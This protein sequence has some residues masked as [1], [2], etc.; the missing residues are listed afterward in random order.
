METTNK[1][2]VPDKMYTARVV[3]EISRLRHERWAI[4]A[5]LS[6]NA[7]GEIETIGENGKARMRQ[8]LLTIHSRLY[9]LTGNKIYDVR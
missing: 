4:L 8:R 5:A 2:V 7:D 3:E 6:H 9:K 1:I